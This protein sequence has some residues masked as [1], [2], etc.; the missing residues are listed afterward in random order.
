[1]FRSTNTQDTINYGVELEKQLKPGSVVCLYG[2]LGAGKTQL[3]KGIAQGLDIKEEIT[4]P[5]FNICLQYDGLNHFDLYRLEAEEDLED[6]GFF[7]MIESD[8]ISVI[9]WADKFPGAIPEDAVKITMK[10]LEDNTRV[11]IEE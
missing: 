5:T 10:V 8:A 3:V 2:D 7:E 9:E 6:I 11:I 4:S 1:M